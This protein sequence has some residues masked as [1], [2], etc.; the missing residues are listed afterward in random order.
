MFVKLSQ[1]AAVATAMVMAMSSQAAPAPLARRNAG[2]AT[3]YT[4]GLGSCGITNTG[5][6]M[7]AAVAANVFDTFPGA[8]ANPNLNPIC[9]RRI[10]ASFGGKTI[11]VTVTD[12]CPGCVGQDLDL[13]PA[14]FNQLADPAVGRIHGVQWSFI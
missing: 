14:A 12:R 9:G 8:T 13:S 1:I 6:D 3:F 10:S 5:S 7:I 11:Q 2:D 4:P